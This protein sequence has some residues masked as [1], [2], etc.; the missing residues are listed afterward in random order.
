MGYPLM[1]CIEAISGAQSANQEVEEEPEWVSHRFYKLSPL[2]IT[3]I[4]SLARPTI[5]SLLSTSTLLLQLYPMHLSFTYNL[6]Y[7]QAVQQKTQK[8][9]TG[10]IRWSSPTQLLAPR[11][12]D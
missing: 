5:Y 7:N 6:T 3:N 9:L 11:Y 1:L 12:S 8:Q 4:T 2:A 10:R